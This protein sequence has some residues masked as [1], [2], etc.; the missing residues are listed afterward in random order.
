MLSSKLKSKFVLDIEFKAPA[1]LSNYAF[2]PLS[3]S[4]AVP[5]FPEGSFYN[6][7]GVKDIKGWFCKYGGLLFLD[8]GFTTDPLVSSYSLFDLLL[9]RL[10]YLFKAGA[11]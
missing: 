3:G 6:S 7:L 2:P 1:N 11:F 4:A 8:L 9:R 10:E 5:K